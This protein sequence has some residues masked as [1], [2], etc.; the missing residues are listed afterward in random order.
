MAED[1]QKS[2]DEIV[3]AKE[4]KDNIVRSMTDTLIVVSP[5]GIIQTVNPA[6]CTLLGYEEKELIGQPISKVLQ[7]NGLQFDKG[8]YSIK[9]E[10]I[11]QCHII[12]NFK[13]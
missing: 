9:K 11:R 1:L 7:D 13:N 3:S 12:I 8:N 4:Y 2:N 6:V 5:H 10:L